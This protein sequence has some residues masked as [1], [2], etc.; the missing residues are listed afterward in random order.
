MIDYSQLSP[1]ELKEL[2]LLSL[3]LDQKIAEKYFEP[4]LDLHAEQYKSNP[5]AGRGSVAQKK[6]TSPWES[7]PCLNL[8][9]A[10][11]PVKWRL[12]ILQPSVIFTQES[13]FL[14]S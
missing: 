7:S 11:N 1:D 2:I 10:I 14:P 5:S 12:P 3:H 6:E 8:P 4:K 13:S 9:K